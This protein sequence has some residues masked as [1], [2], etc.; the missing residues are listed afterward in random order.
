MIIR[1]AFGDITPNDDNKTASNLL[2][3]RWPLP[4]AFLQ[5]L[6]EPNKVNESVI[7]VKYK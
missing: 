6:S 2:D 7:H 3:L 5:A 4:D 1:A